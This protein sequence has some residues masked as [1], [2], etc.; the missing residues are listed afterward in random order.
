MGK[1]YD[2]YATIR[3]SVNDLYVEEGESLAGTIF[4]DGWEGEILGCSFEGDITEE[5]EEIDD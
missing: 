5:T 1:T 4:P 3:I 2:G